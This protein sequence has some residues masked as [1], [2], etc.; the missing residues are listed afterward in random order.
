[1][2]DLNIDGTVAVAI[3]NAPPANTI[4]PDWCRQF[5]QVLDRVEARADIKALHIKS[6]LKIFCAGAD[7]KT[8]AGGFDRGS[9]GICEFIGALR[10]YQVL[11][12][13]I[14][15]LPCTTVAEIA[16]AALGGGFEF[17]LACD[18]RIIAD[19]AKVG[20]PEVGL[21]LLPAIGG[22]Q[23]LTAVCGEGTAKR[24][25]L[26]GE[27][28]SG[29]EALRL[30]MV[31]W[32]YPAAELSAQSDRLIDRLSRMPGRALRSAKACIATQASRPNLGF[33]TE[34]SESLDLFQSDETR[35]AVAEFLNRKRPG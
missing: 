16:G 20:L 8:V 19:E 7:L 4:T 22:T 5:H 14:E 23:R 1:M 3:L 31:Q 30:G 25:I 11:F 26:T 15:N 35:K 27:V 2:I 6:A 32:S 10:E 18:L 17:A 9:D 33:A 12:Q 34:I 24:L 28:V 13:R 21:G 29:S